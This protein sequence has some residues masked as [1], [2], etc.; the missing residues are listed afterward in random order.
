MTK[1]EATDSKGK[2]HKRGTK[3]RTYTHCVVAYPK[4]ETVIV[5]D[6]EYPNGPTVSWAGSPALAMA[7]A[8]TFRGYGYPHVEIVEA[9][10][11]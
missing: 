9:R 5:G 10:Q 3:N 6:T 4:N 11:V 2:L 1:Y 7:R 8:K